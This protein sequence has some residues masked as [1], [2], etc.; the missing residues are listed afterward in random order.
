MQNK[1]HNIIDDSWEM[2]EEFMGGPEHTMR[3]GLVTNTVMN[4]IPVVIPDISELMEVPED[5]KIDFNNL[6]DLNVP[7]L[8]HTSM[9]SFQL[10]V[11]I[12]HD[13]DSNHIQCYPF[14]NLN[15][16]GYWWLYDLAFDM[17][18]TGLVEIRPVNPIIEEESSLQEPTQEMMSHL[19][20]IAIV[21]SAFVYRYQNGEIELTEDSDDFSKINKK[22]SKNNKAPIVNN[23]TPTYV[24]NED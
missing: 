14:G 15:E 11:L 16:G 20:A 4:S 22:R 18:P 5:F 13:K 8:L 17:V 12:V 19:E 2:K 7:V 23:W 10:A 24:K 6:A 21:V 3:V 9:D 1:L